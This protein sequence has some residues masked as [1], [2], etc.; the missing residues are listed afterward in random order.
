M[1]ENIDEINVLYKQ[2]NRLEKEVNEI[3]RNYKCRF[4]GGVSDCNVPADGVVFHKTG[5]DNDK[6]LE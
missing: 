2:F 5:R 3:D 6:S 1:T 4:D